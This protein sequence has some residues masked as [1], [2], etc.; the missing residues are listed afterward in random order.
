VFDRFFR[1]ED[2]GPEGFGLGLAIVRQSVRSLGGHIELDSAPGQGTRVRI[3]LEHAR[4][5]EEAIA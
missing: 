5:R 4:V 1:G 2:R 3:V